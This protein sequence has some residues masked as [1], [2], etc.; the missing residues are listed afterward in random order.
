MNTPYRPALLVLPSAV[1]LAGSLC[2]PLASAE[3]TQVAAKPV[4]AVP[5]ASES[6]APPAKRPLSSLPYTPSLE[7]G[8]MDRSVDPCSDFYRYS[9]GGWMQKNPVPPDQARWTVY[10]KLYDENQQFLWGLLEDA[11]RE[12][13]RPP[14]QQKIGDYFAACMDE[15]AVEARGAQAL[16]GDLA[17]ITA[18]RRKE[19]LSRFL[20]GMHQRMSSGHSAALFG[21][22]ADQ[23]P[24][25]S[26]Q[27]IAWASASGLGLPD[28]DY[29]TKTDAKS[30]ETRGRYQAH[31]A[32]M[33]VLSGVQKA[34]ADR[35]AATV[36]RIETTLAQA[37]LT[38]VE[39]RDPYKVYH[40]M[41]L[42]ELSTLA[43]QIRWN[44]YLGSL[45]APAIAEVNVTEPKFFSVLSAL[46]ASEPLPNLQTYLRWHAVRGRAPYLSS[47]FV[48]ADF[49]FYR[50]YL[51]GVKQQQPRWKRCVGWVDRDLGEALGQVFVERAF[52]VAVKKKALDMVQRIE[53]V[54]G[55]RLNTL[56]WMSA[57]TKKQALAKLTSMRNKI[58]YPDKWRDYSALAIQRDDFLGN[59]DRAYAFEVRRQL[60]KIGKPIDRGEW[61]M[62]PPTVN[63]YYNASMNDMNFPAAV[64]L[65][66]LF[67]LKLDD[68]PNYGNT[69]GTIGHELIHGFDDEGRNFD[70][71]GNLRD[72]WT[73]ADAKEFEARSSCIA[74]Q[75]AQYVIVDDIK[76]NSKLTLG[77]DVAD[78][79]G[80]ILAWE[81]WQDATHNQRLRPMDGL[82]PEQ[83]FFVGFAQ[84]TCE[85]QRDEDKRVSALTNP[86]SPGIYRINGVVANMPEFARAF[87][88]KPTA[89]L[90]RKN[91]CKVW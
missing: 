5:A 54:M 82:S 58:G 10:G 21:F 8:F 76:I 57:A 22:G 15:S 18:L 67:D 68:A 46:I 37:S 9:C 34:Q 36:L 49:D 85:N 29:Y 35:D 3:P 43:P 91:I 33:L 73:P 62:T 4:V 14:A 71:A 65:P 78:L 16:A 53:K 64:L 61:G 80:L 86:H 31:V 1:W 30:V 12:G 63:A 89:K 55:E 25:N 19:D 45:G 75:Y 11:R 7:P 41:G 44:E 77:E 84:W 20:G 50:G 48:Q 81:A 13:A 26:E 2:P 72:W 69:G 42:A 90:V 24:G 52:P 79:G 87:A 38:R 70:A 59:V 60:A 23:D 27:V 6:P 17:A 40:K 28:R 74:D 51:R 56:S 39:K 88:C 83:R 66:P 47:A 32:A